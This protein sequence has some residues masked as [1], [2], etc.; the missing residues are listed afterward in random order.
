MVATLRQL[1]VDGSGCNCYY[2]TYI[3]IPTKPTPSRGGKGKRRILKKMAELPKDKTEVCSV[4]LFP[5]ARMG[6][7]DPG[8]R[9]TRNGAQFAVGS[10]LNA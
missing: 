5:L 9:G 7:L 6:R 1:D 2:Q 4:F 8:E 10:Y 3:A